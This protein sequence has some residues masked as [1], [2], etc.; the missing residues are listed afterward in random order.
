MPNNRQDIR[1]QLINPNNIAPY[2]PPELQV[3]SLLGEGAQGVVYR[4]SVNG[5]DA[6]IKVLF[7]GQ[8]VQRF[9]RETLALRALD[10]YSI[11]KLLWSGAVHFENNELSVAATSLIVGN[12]LSD[13]L[14]ARVLTDDE[15]AILAFDVSFAILHMWEKRIVHRDLKPSNLM[16]G[17]DGRTRVIDLGLARHL[18]LSSLTM[19]G[20]SWGTLGYLSP[21]QAHAVRQLTCKS[22]MYALG[23][24]LLECI[25]GEHPTQYDQEQLFNAGYHE[26]LP[27]VATEWRYADLI[28]SLLQPHPAARPRPSNILAVL[29]DFAPNDL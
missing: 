7:P 23:V 1:E 5:I 27:S 25:I 18:D 17:N 15:L 3:E 11:V 16:I 22:D 24:I 29:R 4:G 26:Q 10:C 14:D 9:E 12:P 21:E 2:L 8:L 6:A 28:K 19:L 13:L 20:A